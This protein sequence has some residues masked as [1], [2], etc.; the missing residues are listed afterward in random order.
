M[1]DDSLLQDIESES[2]S[3]EELLREMREERVPDSLKRSMEEMER[4]L[5][6]RP[7]EE[8]PERVHFREPSPTRVVQEKPEED[9]EAAA[10]WAR[11]LPRRVDDDQDRDWPRRRKVDPP[12]DTETKEH[13]RLWRMPVWDGT[14]GARKCPPC[15]CGLR[16]CLGSA[17]GR[18]VHDCALCWKC[19]CC[20]H[21]P[22]VPGFDAVLKAT[23]DPYSKDAEELKCY[24]MLL[25]WARCPR[26]GA[27]LGAGSLPSIFPGQLKR[28]YDGAPANPFDSSSASTIPDGLFAE[29]DYCLDERVGPP[30]VDRC[31]RALNALNKLRAMAPKPFYRVFAPAARERLL[32]AHRLRAG[33]E[34]DAD[35]ADHLEAVVADERAQAEAAG[36]RRRLFSIAVDPPDHVRQ[37]RLAAFRSAEE[38]Y[39][40]QPGAGVIAHDLASE[41]GLLLN[42]AIGIVDATRTDLGRASVKFPGHDKP[43]YVKFTNLRL[44][45]V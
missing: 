22:D 6:E 35:L 33:L 36:T 26:C 41:R 12:V 38:P 9:A 1:D 15:D 31:T 3:A 11:P 42:G 32:L 28:I 27:Q 40:P 8:S 43:I 44:V 5:G 7:Q 19:R 13:R 37:A 10:A 2:F 39:A 16:H 24:G 29:V 17:A 23:R 14:A 34:G 4:N 25:A 30:T 45:P 21:A 20:F 18:A